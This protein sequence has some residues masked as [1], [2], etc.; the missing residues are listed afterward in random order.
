MGARDFCN[1]GISPTVERAFWEQV[2]RALIEHGADGYTGSIAEKYE[3][4]LVPKPQQFTAAQIAHWAFG[5]EE[6]AGGT[7]TEVPIV[8]HEIVASMASLIRDKWGPAIALEMARS[9]VEV[10]VTE[11]QNADLFFGSSPF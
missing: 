4:V 7:M 8:A 2:T 5:W 10:E 6:S 9:E 3:F 1:V 11:G